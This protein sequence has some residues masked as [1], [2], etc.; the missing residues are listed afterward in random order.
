MEDKTLEKIIKFFEKIKCPV[1]VA[2]RKNLI[3]NLSYE[4]A[5]IYSGEDIMFCDKKNEKFEFEERHSLDISAFYDRNINKKKLLKRLE[6][7]GYVLCNLQTE[8][9][10]FNKPI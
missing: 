10:K 6:Q 5:I 7:G 4:Y 8:N 3:D 9:I 1:E 2:L